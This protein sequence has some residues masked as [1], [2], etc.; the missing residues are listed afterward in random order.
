M[1]VL[2]RLGRMPLRAR[3]TALYGLAF[4][5]G[6]GILVAVMYGIVALELDRQP[7][8]AFEATG[9]SPG[10]VLQDPPQDPQRES[11]ELEPLDEEVIQRIEAA[12]QRR[13]DATLD[14]FLVQSLIALGVVGLSAGV[15]GYV[16]AGRALR[17]LSHITATARRVAERSL[18]ERIDLDG[19][20]DEIKELADTFDDMLARL[21]RSFSGQHHFVGNA[22]HELRTPLAVTRTLLEVALSDPEAS[23]D[24]KQV[25]K[26]LLETNARSEM[27]VGKLLTLARSEN[28]VTEWHS[29]DLSVLIENSISACTDEIRER[30]LNVHQDLHSVEVVGDV[31]LLE[32]MVLNLVQN[33]VRHNHPL[34][35][36]LWVST[37]DDREHVGFEIRNTGQTVREHDLARM[38]EPFVRLA[39]ERTGSSQGLG[40]SIV[41][42]VV[43][44]HGGSVTASPREE[45]GLLI[46]VQLPHGDVHSAR[47]EVAG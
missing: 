47:P 43:Q 7:S 33:A 2:G 32:Q 41:K 30:D 39:R 34:G 37:F 10:T 17:P 46:R 23:D 20:A 12:E 24:L 45:G 19:P 40:L 14:S 6:G 31:D 28:A 35:G 3:L 5:L 1:K 26:T 9:M 27:L 18:H 29:A 22:S 15:L 21:D 25:G 16:V 42:S 11:T 8:V 38:F 4:F 13:R 36:H 44:S